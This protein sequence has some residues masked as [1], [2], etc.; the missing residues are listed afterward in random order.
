MLPSE[1]S[2]TI[3][4]RNSALLRRSRIVL[5]ALCDVVIWYSVHCDR[6]GLLIVT[7]RLSVRAARAEAQ[8]NYGANHGPDGDKCLACR[9]FEISRQTDEMLARKS[10]ATHSVSGAPPKSDHWR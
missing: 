2:T 10:S 4:A 6:C 3:G 8:L 7:S 5:L 9:K 1:V